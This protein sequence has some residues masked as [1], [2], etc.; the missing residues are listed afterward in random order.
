MTLLCLGISNNFDFISFVSIFFYDVIGF[1]V[2][3][4][5]QTIYAIVLH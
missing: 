3:L 1:G 2:M 4:Q 5:V